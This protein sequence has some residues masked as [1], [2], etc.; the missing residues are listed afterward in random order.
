MAGMKIKARMIAGFAAVLLLVATALIALML[1]NLSNTIERA[2]ERE[3]GGYRRAFTAAVAMSTANGEALAMLAAELPDAKAAF[4]AGDRRRLGELFVQPFA[5]LKARLGVEQMQFHLPPATSFFRAHMPNKFGDDLSSFRRTV[6]EANRDHKAVMGLENGVGGM[7]IRAVLPV[8]RDG[9]HIGTVEFGMNFG[10]ALADGFKRQFGV[11]VTIAA[12]KSAVKQGGG[13][14]EEIKQVATT[15]QA[16]FT[17]EDWKRVLAGEEILRRGIRDG[18]PV[19]AVAAPVLDYQH[20]PAAVVEI[21]MDSSE[22]AAQYASARGQSLAVAAGVLAAGL[23]VAYLLSRGIAAPLSAMTKAMHRLADGDLEV[24]VPARDRR[25]EIGEMAGAVEV[26]KRNAV[27]KV[28]MEDEERIRLET[29]RQAEAERKATE[30]AV[31]AEVA[32]VAGAASRGDLDRRIELAGKD[33]FLLDLCRDV[34]QLV[35]R[36]GAAFKDVA[37][38]MAAI[39][40][41]DLSRRITADYAGLFGAVKADVNATADKLHAIVGDIGAA[42]SEINTAASE[43]AAGSMDL[44]ERSE[45]Q[46][47]ALEETAASM[48][49]LAATVRRNAAN[50]EQ[51][52]RLAAEAR[53]VASSGDR[54]VADAVAAMGRIE[55]S[56]HKIGE[57]VGLIDEIAFQTNLLALNAAVEAARAGDAGKG[58]AVV[59]QEVRNLA[60][61]SADASREIKTL[62]STSTAEVQQGA[63][64]VKGTGRVLDEIFVSVKRVADIVG[65]IAAASGE[66]AEGI[67]QVNAAV[68]QMDEMT[69][70]NAALV[71]QSAA[72]ARAL[73]EQA[74]GLGR[75]MGFFHGR[76]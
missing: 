19:V 2:E 44:S 33:G 27:D 47:S 16:F 48:E 25:D 69:Q 29:Q 71:E 53:D 58:F 75:L 52:D 32:E 37:G 66:Q 30:A 60:Q 10:Q 12:A 13:V 35:D 18:M 70:Q 4:A 59:A 11:D 23:A 38:V 9:L 40:H 22:F 31:I 57:I 24:V 46:A 62:I 54:L 28:R 15:A 17:V 65:E 49:E 21:V 74:E 56:S 20:K 26:F 3:L 55:A 68:G 14:E 51:A 45:Q 39:A 7:G 61:R 41:G 43:V 50:A 8:S 67:Q 72:A 5:A 1:D 36:T 76:R 73:Q 6:V 42:S 63:D 64:L 34:N